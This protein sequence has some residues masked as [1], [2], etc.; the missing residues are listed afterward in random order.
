M[1]FLKKCGTF[2]VYIKVCIAV[3]PNLKYSLFSSL[4]VYI[5]KK[6]PIWISSTL[7]PFREA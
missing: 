3:A 2:T 1:K 5:L 6:S 4:A 7:F